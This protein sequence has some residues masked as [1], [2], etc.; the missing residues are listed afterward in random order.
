MWPTEAGSVLG[1][2]RGSE[3]PTTLDFHHLRAFSMDIVTTRRL[4]GLTGKDRTELKNIVNDLAYFEV[5]TRNDAD[6]TATAI[7]ESTGKGPDAVRGVEWC[8]VTCYLGRFS[9][10]EGTP[11]QEDSVRQCSSPPAALVARQTMLRFRAVRLNRWYREQLSCCEPLIG[12][13]CVG[14]R[15]CRRVRRK[16]QGR[17]RSRRSHHGTKFTSS[18]IA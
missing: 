18:T 16:K 15:T 14:K 12:A 11:T 6:L 9:L 2:I 5:G 13:A 1:P 3:D 4:N 8:A 10:Q 17:H 7:R